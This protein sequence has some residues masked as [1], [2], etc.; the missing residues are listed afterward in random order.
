[1]MALGAAVDR[2]LF[3]IA[4]SRLRYERRVLEDEIRRYHAQRNGHSPEDVD[5]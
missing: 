2:D 4:K 1:M 5:S 3:G